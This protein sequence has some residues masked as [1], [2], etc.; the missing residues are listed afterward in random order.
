MLRSTSFLTVAG[1]MLCAS[2]ADAQIPPPPPPAVGS[3]PQVQPPPGQAPPGQVPAAPPP[4]PAAPPRPRGARPDPPGPSELRGRPPDAAGTIVAV[5]PYYAQIR[6]PDG[7]YRNV[8]LHNGTVINPTGTTL[9][10][11][12]RVSILGQALPDGA[13]AA[14]EI[15]LTPGRGPRPGPGGRERPGPGGQPG[16]GALGPGGPAPA[17]P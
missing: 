11:G 15:D 6:T 3:P 5:K 10:L 14:N 4:A 17:R 8:A 16:P 1:L 13:I 7:R 9:A 12:M 2:G